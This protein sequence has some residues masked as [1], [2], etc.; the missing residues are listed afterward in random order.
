MRKREERMA[1]GE[2]VKAAAA[3][4]WPHLLSKVTSPSPPP[5]GL[6]RT[7]HVIGRETMGGA[8]PSSS[9]CDISHD[10]SHVTPSGNRP[11]E[12]EVAYFNGK[13][14][15]TQQNMTLIIH[16]HHQRRPKT[17]VHGQR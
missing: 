16:H 14:S 13:L 8:M 2:T 1:R 10:G 11:T 6:R 3:A 9:P 17:H 5:V 12:I 15:T 7:G 4:V